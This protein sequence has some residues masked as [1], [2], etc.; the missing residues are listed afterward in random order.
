[1]VK[2]CLV[3][4]SIAFSCSGFAA[5]T[6]SHFKGSDS[7][8]GIVSDAIIAAGLNKEIVYEGGGS[9]LGET[10][11]VNGEQ[12]IAPMSRKMKA[13]AVQALKE[14]GIGVEAHVIA[15][16][17]IGIFVHETSTVNEIDLPALKQI[18]TCQITKW[19]QLPNS[20][21][22]GAIKAYRRNDAS[23]T[24]DTFK[25]LVGVKDFGA[26]VQVLA[27]TSDIAEKTATEKNA[28]GYSGA[29]A[30][31]DG[32]KALSVAPT[33]G[34]VSIPLNVNTVRN[35]QYPLARKLY[36]YEVTGA[37]TPNES[38]DKLLNS[39]LLDRSFLDPIVQDHEY[40][41]ID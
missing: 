32:N 38:E 24:T 9:G 37:K 17:G 4:V 12:G 7:M 35:S 6:L 39:Y 40:Y 28:I 10:A 8:A 27:E 14:K 18:Y 34:A 2:N 23:G 11:L 22:N 19:E 25:N 15:L 33:L 3:L 31:R 21:M 30:K 20:R 13:E 29:T 36:I 5:E 1:M 26:C 16:D 41:T